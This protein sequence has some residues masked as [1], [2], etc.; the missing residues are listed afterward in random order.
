[1][2]RY[3]VW[4]VVSLVGLS[5]CERD[6]A[7]TAPSTASAAPSASTAPMVGGV[8][9]LTGKTPSSVSK[10]RPEAKSGDD[11]KA[12]FK[13][14]SEVVKA[15]AAAEDKRVLIRGYAGQLREPGAFIELYECEYRGDR[16]LLEAKYTEDQ[17]ALVRG[18]PSHKPNGPCPRIHVEI[19]G[20]DEKKGNPQGEIM[21]VLDVRPDPLP[22]DLPSGVDFIS[23][24][25]IF[26]RGPSAVGKVADMPVRLH[27][28]E[29][30]AGVTYY[31]LEATGCSPHGGREAQVMV[32]ETDANRAALASIPKGRS[33]LRGRFRITGAPDA[34]H[35]ARWKV[36][37]VGIGDKAIRAPEP[38]PNP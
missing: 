34:E 9:Q 4:A 10:N 37:L 2:R 19:T 3:A 20:F 24:D 18:M 38:V 5:A 7:A 17:L 1:M 36:E 31:V 27:H 12:E 29:D 6:Q 13:E 21:D 11:P 28:K 25:D 26:L 22:L 8:E 16:I 14:L 32:A 35:P 30:K 15:K 33:C 23:I